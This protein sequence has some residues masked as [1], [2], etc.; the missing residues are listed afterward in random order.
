MLK[1]LYYLSGPLLDP[2]QYVHVSP[3]LRRPESGRILY[4]WPHQCCKDGKDHFCWPAD[5]I[6]LMQLRTSL[7]TFAAKGKLLTFVQL[8][9]H[10]AR[11][12]GKLFSSQ[13]A[14]SMLW[15]KGLHFLKYQTLKFQS[16]NYTRL[17]L[18]L[19]WLMLNGS[20][21]YWFTSHSSV[22]YYQETCW[23]HSDPTC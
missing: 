10:W 7:A 23:G 13:S 15:Y 3:I 21:T 4:M 5:N 18:A 16:L 11:A 9:V 12:S 1:L 19:S 17:L 22:L 14:A 2:P 6:F 20:K 8:G